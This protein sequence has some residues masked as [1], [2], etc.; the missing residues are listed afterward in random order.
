LHPKLIEVGM[1]DG[2]SVPGH[3]SIRTQNAAGLRVERAVEG[4]V[5]DP[6]AGAVRGGYPPTD[7]GM[8]RCAGDGGFVVAPA[9]YASGVD[10]SSIGPWRRM[11]SS[12]LFTLNG[13]VAFNLPKTVTVLGEALLLG[14]VAVHVYVAVT[15]PS[16]PTYFMV[17][18]AVLSAGC[19]VAAAVTARG[20]KPGTAQRGWYLGSIVCL[21]FLAVYLGSRMVSLPGLQT[22]TGR[23][24]LAPGTVAMALAAG[25]I[26]VHATVLSG[27]NVAY[28]QRQGWLD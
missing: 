16:L 7:R 9:G 10:T 28:P 3:R 27:I 1:L 4:H 11:W 20:A 22:L 8:P 24:D 18:A 12:P 15:Q 21:G 26:G 5:L 23:W 25:F 13:W 6:R 17:Y 14:I 19:V 2:Q